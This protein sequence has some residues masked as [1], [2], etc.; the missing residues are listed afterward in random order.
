MLFWTGVTRSATPIL[1]EESQ[2]VDARLS[3]F[4]TLRDLASSAVEHLRRGD[5]DALGRT[6]RPSW[7]AKRSLALGVT[8]TQIDRAIDGALAAGA[9]GAK[10]TGAGGGGFLLLM[11]PPEKQ[12]P[13]RQSLGE[14]REFPIK[15]DRFGSRVVFN[16]MYDL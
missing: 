11:A 10:V 16:H 12:E 14:L 7:E 5:L 3:W 8:N 15:L 4:H 9:T 6:M 13:V 1:S 2:N